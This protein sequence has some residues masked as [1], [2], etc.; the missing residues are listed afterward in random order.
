MYVP[1][2]IPVQAGGGIVAVQT[3]AS[4]ARGAQIVPV[5]G[6]KVTYQG[7]GTEGMTTGNRGLHFDMPPPHE[8]AD[9]ML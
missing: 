5:F 7:A 2:G 3:V 4:G 9:D 1:V 8:E 6:A